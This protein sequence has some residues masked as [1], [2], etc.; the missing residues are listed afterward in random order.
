MAALYRQ[1]QVD[2]SYYNGKCSDLIIENLKLEAYDYYTDGKIIYTK[3]PLEDE[4][5]KTY[6]IVKLDKDTLKI[7]SN[8]KDYN[9]KIFEG[10]NDL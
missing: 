2:R 7:K 5:S 6:T 10:D 3:Q 9:M 4:Y 8:Q 1:R